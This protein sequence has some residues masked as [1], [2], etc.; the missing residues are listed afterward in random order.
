MHMGYGIGKRSLE[1]PA[2]EGSSSKSGV[3]ESYTGLPVRNYADRHDS[4]L[5]LCRFHE[6]CELYL[7]PFDTT[8]KV[9]GW[10]T[11]QTLLSLSAIRVLPF[12]GDRS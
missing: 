5:V 12:S 9:S 1:L 7:T 10:L 3:V 2:R 4:N 11:S 6:R 8:F